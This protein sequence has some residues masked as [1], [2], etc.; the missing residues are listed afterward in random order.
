MFG[1]ECCVT[2]HPLGNV[3]VCLPSG[4][5]PLRGADRRVPGQQQRTLTPAMSAE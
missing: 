3:P 1:I 2:R 4:F 5:C